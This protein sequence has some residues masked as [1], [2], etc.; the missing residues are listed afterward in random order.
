[1]AS[2]RSPPPL[3][4]LS[5]HEGKTT[6]SRCNPGATE[7][8]KDMFSLGDRQ[9][10]CQPSLL[11]PLLAV[12]MGVCFPFFPTRT[13]HMLA[14]KDLSRGSEKASGFVVLF[15][16]ICFQSLSFGE[17]RERRAD[18]VTDFPRTEGR[19]LLEL[20][21][22]RVHPLLLSLLQSPKVAG[23][24]FCQEKFSFSSLVLE[25]SVW[26]ATCRPNPGSTERGANHSSLPLTELLRT[27]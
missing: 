5:K 3:T 20:H 21:V 25:A 2:G 15:P 8:L 17:A 6:T 22:P 4:T 11:R 18:S 26:S 19:R 10:V 16:A 14:K 23:S 13:A 1:M 9:W 27:F 7:Y 24:H 12:N